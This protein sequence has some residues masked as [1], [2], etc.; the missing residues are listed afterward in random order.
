LLNTSVKSLKAF[1]E[2]SSWV[3]WN[4]FQVLLFGSDEVTAARNCDSSFELLSN[5]R[6]KKKITNHLLKM[7]ADARSKI[8]F[9]LLASLLVKTI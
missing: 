1:S 5:I 7:A 4:D 3:C 8:S 6:R 9:N 2:F